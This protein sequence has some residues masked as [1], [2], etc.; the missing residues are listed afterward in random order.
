MHI[1]R[2]NTQVSSLKEFFVF[3]A[4]RETLNGV[5]RQ[6]IYS[7]RTK[8]FRTFTPARL[9]IEKPNDVIDTDI[10]SDGGKFYRFSKNESAKNIFMEV[11]D[12][13]EGEWMPVQGFPV[14][15]FA[16]YEGPECFRMAD[17]RW[18]LI[19]DY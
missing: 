12:S 5:N 14:N 16:G 2:K 13:L 10:V 17:G 7:A 9:Y 4:S 18:C 8:D 1:K 11:A 15:S 6:R 19:V 3:W